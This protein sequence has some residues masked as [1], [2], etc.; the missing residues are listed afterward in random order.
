MAPSA[1]PFD[2]G[3]SMPAALDEGGILAIIEAFMDAA[4]RALAAGFQVIEVHAAH[5]YL[6][7]QFLSPL[8]NRRTDHYGGSFVNRT[9]LLRE[10]A[11]SRLEIGT[12]LAKVMQQAGQFRE[13]LRSETLSVASGAIPH[14]SKVADQRLPFTLRT[15]SYAVCI[16]VHFGPY[17]PN[18]C[19]WT[20]C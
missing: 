16:I 15:T 12:V 17:S 19:F 1:L 14:L 7:H 4:R 8:A 9:R 11:Q 13:R 20:T 2:A 10:V 5:G 6:L 3:W 18:E